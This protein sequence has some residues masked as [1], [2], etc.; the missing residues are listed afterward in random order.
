MRKTIL[1]ALA[2]LAFLPVAA[3]AQTAQPVLYS[4]TATA[5]Q[6]LFA[7]A[8]DQYLDTLMYGEIVDP[9][10]LFK[11]GVPTPGSQT[12]ANEVGFGARFKPYYIGA[13][14]S[15]NGQIVGNIA[16][17][18]V[19]QYRDDD[20]I[21]SP[22]GQ[23]VVGKVATTSSSTDYRSYSY[24]NPIAL[25]GLTIGNMQIGIR[26]SLRITDNSSHGSY[27][28]AG[29]L[30]AFTRTTE[31]STATTITNI[32]TVDGAA[33]EVVTSADSTEYAIGKDGDFSLVNDLEAGLSMPLALP[34][35]KFKLGAK[36]RVG[37]SAFDYSDSYASETRSIVTGMG[38][39]AY[40]PTVGLPGERLEA[41]NDL[42]SYEVVDYA[43]LS[44]PFYI[45]PA[46]TAQLEYPF[47][48][49]QNPAKA[50]VQLGY[51]GSFALYNASVAN[52]P[53]TTLSTGT[54]SERH[55]YARDVTFNPVSGFYEVATVET[56]EYLGNDYAYRTE[57]SAS[58]G[59]GLEVTPSKAVR[60]AFGV[61]PSIGTNTYKYN[62]QSG[63]VVIAT[64]DDGDA[65]AVA[66]DPD[67]SVTTTT[68]Y[69][70]SYD[71][72]YA[73]TS[74]D[75]D[76]AA[77]VQ[78]FLY[79]DKF[80]LNLSTAAN[81]ELLYRTTYTTNY[82]DLARQTQTVLVN[83]VTTNIPVATP[84][85]TI[86]HADGDEYEREVGDGADG[87]IMSF[88]AGF[89]YFLNPNI[90]LDLVATNPRA[91]NLSSTTDN[92]GFF[93]LANYTV[94]LTIKLPPQGSKE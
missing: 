48:F 49:F 45:R 75:V 74:A 53:G 57:N 72:S 2:L 6:T 89:T 22:D 38:Y 66:T 86:D 5:T 79:K 62:R 71:Y 15:Y 21:L 91:F 30:G 3:I 25:F 46:L 31:T 52:G 81:T 7:E 67:D 40:T 65:V 64:S 8:A 32:Q 12:S 85:S 87:N 59:L 93:N 4:T 56:F 35:G 88:Q 61:R 73:R 13:Y 27:S 70:Q 82:T 63:S 19:A 60:F 47:S 17:D 29:T 94:Q 14:Y 90:M 69:N 78:L 39:P 83:G 23:T 42:E 43:Y 34:F 55:S 9:V 1:C 37:V 20:L 51:D 28:P 76:F 92:G 77:A 26:D 84:V 24:N 10:F 44:K 80:R 33:T 50:T 58:L 54:G 18:S 11:F 68:T 36:A 41:I 16:G